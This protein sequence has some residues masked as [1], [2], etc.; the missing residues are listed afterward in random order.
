MTTNVDILFKELPASSA[1]YE[2]KNASGISS[3]ASAHGSSDAQKSEKVDTKDK[4]FTE[5]LDEQPS[6][7][8]ENNSA[9]KKNEANG[10][11]EGHSGY[12]SDAPQDA[13]GQNPQEQ[14]VNASSAQQGENI[15][16]AQT[17]PTAELEIEAQVTTIPV[18]SSE[19][20]NTPQQPVISTSASMPGNTDK[21]INTPGQ[22]GNITENTAQTDSSIIKTEPNAVKDA[23]SQEIA[24]HDTPVTTD[25]GDTQKAVDVASTPVSNSEST[26]KSDAPTSEEAAEN[27]VKQEIQQQLTDTA[28]NKDNQAPQ[29]AANIETGSL[30]KGGEQ[31]S[32]VTNTISQD[33]NTAPQKVVVENN[34]PGNTD[35]IDEAEAL[36]LPEQDNLAAGKTTETVTAEAAKAIPA[37]AVQNPN[38]VNKPSNAS[39]K[40]NAKSAVAT[41]DPTSSQAANNSGST[42]SGQV[43]PNSSALTSAR[44][45]EIQ[46]DFSGSGQ[47]SEPAPLLPPIQNNQGQLPS[48]SLLAVQDISLQKAPGNIPSTI[49]TDTT[50]MTRMINEQITV[51]IN[52]QIVNGQN[53]FT[54]RLQPAELGQVDI[55]LEF[56]ADGKMQASMVVEN[57]RTLTMLQRDQGALEKA[58]QDAGINMSNKNMNFSLMKQGGQN[59]GQQFAG[60]NNSTN[61]DG[62]LEQLSQQGT[63]QQV[64]MGYSD[65]TLDISV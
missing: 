42:S 15:P 64:S 41:P 58:L 26:L 10:N 50:T 65:Q 60:N 14:S 36:P 62:A 48:N 19:D 39:S 32:P 2:K 4:T 17:S 34:L 43:T 16:P 54:I 29:V 63:M 27:P 37:A 30:Q 53:N 24:A 5:H 6:Y 49:N 25:K 47:K 8:A 55:R 45:S 13:N 31:N 21:S 7:S 33:K 57:E 46:L 44:T 61:N 23:V 22:S 56:A 38:A 52:R 40:T 1:A 11:A 20:K 59:A 9:V 3:T 51:A 28:Q 12:G 18:A 35:T